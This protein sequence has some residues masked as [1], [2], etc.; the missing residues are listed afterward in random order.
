M[1]GGSQR[2]GSGQSSQAS[3]TNRGRRTSRPTRLESR[4]VLVAT[5]GEVTERQ[6]VE[7]LVQALRSGGVAVSVATAHGDPDPVSVVTKCI[8]ERDAQKKKG[9]AFD[10]CVCLIDVDD[11]AHLAEAITLAEQNGIQMLVSNVKFELWLLWHVDASTG[12]KTSKQLDQLMVK[13]GLFQKKKHLSAKFP[14]GKVDHA[15][16]VARRADPDLAAC[17]KGKNPSSAMPVLVEILRGNS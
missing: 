1:S 13:H 2:A 8:Q 14:I 12:A 15:V 9:K 17:R 7:T 16:T 10:Q 6:Y 4:R 5:E 11:H 3:R